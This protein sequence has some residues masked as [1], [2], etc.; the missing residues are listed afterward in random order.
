MRSW[1]GSWLIY[2]TFA[3]GPLVSFVSATFGQAKR[4]KDV[5]GQT[6]WVEQGNLSQTLGWGLLI[7]AF[8][9]AMLLFLQEKNE[10]RQLQRSETLF[11]LFALVAIL[12]SV[13]WNWGQWQP[14]DLGKLAV[15]LLCSAAAFV[16]GVPENLSRTLSKMSAGL[17]FLTAAFALL[18]TSYSL[19]EC[20]V[21]KCT[22][23]GFL[24][25][26]FFPHENFLAL[27]LAAT[28]PFLRVLDNL[29]LKNLAS[30]LC[31]TLIYMSGS[32]IVY[33]AVMLFFVLQFAKKIRNYSLIIPF[34]VGLSLLFFATVRGTDFTD[35]GLIY[36]ALWSELSEK[37]IFG[38]GPQSLEFAFANG[39]LPG[40]LPSHEHGIAPH[41][42]SNFGLLAFTAIFLFLVARTRRLAA[43]DKPNFAVVDALPLLVLSITFSTETPL[44][45]TY[46]GVFS[47]AWYLFLSRNL[48][49]SSEPRPNSKTDSV[50]QTV[51]A[52]TR[53]T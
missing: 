10:I 48:L 37:W 13:L 21:D 32:R 45:F 23:F 41:I 51:Q 11:L 34:S 39:K 30:L 20:R 3:S 26:S 31:L 42:I 8:G 44:V 4:T 16:I 12:L 19:T 14:I 49:H 24:L 2:V 18:N 43:G 15:F 25:N 22:E 40:F 47:W 53:I 17:V 27:T 50:S 7:V 46:S 36:S 52:V 9:L 38:S 29:W 1:A 33:F 6:Q 28:L 35:R 5:F